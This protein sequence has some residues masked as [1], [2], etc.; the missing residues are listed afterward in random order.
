[1]SRISKKAAKKAREHGRLLK[2]SS[3]DD[4]KAPND[5]GKREHG[6]L[7]EASSWD[8]PK[9]PNDAKATAGCQRKHRTK[10]NL[11]MINC[12]LRRPS[13]SVKESSWDDPKAPNDARC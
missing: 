5:A 13:F 12:V 10:R 6:R 7:L 9:A 8:D 1:M 3:W 4:P 2:V 11:R